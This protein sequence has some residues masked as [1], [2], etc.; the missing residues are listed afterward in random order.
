VASVTRAEPIGF[1]TST[2][3]ALPM[4]N[5]TR[6]ATNTFDPVTGQFRFTNAIAPGSPQRFYRLQ[7]P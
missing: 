3:A 1:L 4:A 2:N 5:W 6:T 7:A